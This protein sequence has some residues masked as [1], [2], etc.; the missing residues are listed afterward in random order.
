MK[1]IGTIGSI[2][3]GDNKIIS[4]AFSDW[5]AI[6]EGTFIKFDNDSQFYVAAH[7]E[8]R[9]YLKNFITLESS[10]IRINEDCG[11]NIN[12]G[13]TLYISYKEYELSTIYKIIS[14]GRE[15]RINDQLTLSGGIPSLN[16]TDNTLNSTKFI[17]S[18]IGNDGEIAELNII[19]R[20]KYI[21]APPQITDLKGGSGSLASLEV[22]FKLTD[23]RSFIEKDVQKVEFKSAATIISL[24]YGLPEG[25]KEGK[26]SIEKWEIILAS[27]YQGENRIAAPFQITRD[28]TPNYK[29]PL[30]TKNSLNQELI[31][32][33]ALALL[34][35]K[36][37]ELENQIKELKGNKN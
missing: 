31:V 36:I 14:A 29:I 12:E 22:G 8:K 23:H 1:I 35:R 20:G 15:Y 2:R 21:D 24:V 9:T 6:R 19:N 32:N 26:L 13:D 33:H 11:V 3:K 7:S 5:S 4:S 28:F 17:V 30:I 10:V 16:I 27:N 25:I 37:A 34:D 18:K